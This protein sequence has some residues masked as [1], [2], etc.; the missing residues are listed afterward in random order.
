MDSQLQY[1]SE[2]DIEY[3][4]LRHAFA[5]AQTQDSQLQYEPARGH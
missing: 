5:V 2:G 3:E 4:E 1:E